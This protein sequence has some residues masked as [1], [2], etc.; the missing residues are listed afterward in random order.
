MLD[1]RKFLSGHTN[2]RSGLNVEK[3]ENLSDKLKLEIL[4]NELAEF[5]KLVAG[6]N[7]LLEAIGKM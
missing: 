5:Q 2:L 1:I 7:K 4:H 3:L 6:H